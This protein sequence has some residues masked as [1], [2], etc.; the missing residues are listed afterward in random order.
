MHISKQDNFLCEWNSD[1]SV[2]TQWKGEHWLFFL[3]GKKEKGGVCICVSAKRDS[4]WRRPVFF[5]C[6]SFIVSDVELTLH[7]YARSMGSYFPEGATL[8]PLY[9]EQQRTIFCTRK[10][11]LLIWSATSEKH[12]AF[13]FEQGRRKKIER[14][15]VRIKLFDLM[16]CWYAYFLCIDVCVCACVYVYA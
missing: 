13:N 3:C 11:T 14:K 6:C 16:V 1:K 10:T 12:F 5:L 15:N 9:N 4:Y 7:A 8:N 2:T